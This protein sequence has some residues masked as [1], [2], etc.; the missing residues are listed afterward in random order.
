[1]DSASTQINLTFRWQFLSS[2]FVTLLQLIALVLLGRYLDFKELGAYALFQIIFRFAIFVFEPGM[3]FSLVQRHE[4]GSLLVKRLLERQL[5]Y[6]G[7][8]LILFAVLFILDPNRD[9]NRIILPGFIL[10]LVIGLGAL[11]HNKLILMGK[12]REIAW[13]QALS[14]LGEFLWIIGMVTFVEPLWVF[15]FGL[16]I[17]YF[18]FYGLCFAMSFGKVMDVPSAVLAE[19][20][21]RHIKPARDQMLSQLLSFLQGQYDTLLISG[22]FGMNVLGPYNL[23]TEYSYLAFSKINPL[24]HK[25]YFPALSKA[26]RW[27]SDAIDIMRKNLASYLLVM[28]CIYILLWTNRE[29]LLSM[30]YPDKSDELARMSGFILVVA[31]IKAVNNVLTGYLLAY[32]A[33][34]WILRWNLVLTLVNYLV[35]AVFWWMELPLG[36]FLAFAIG[37]SLFFMLAG[38][39]FLQRVCMKGETLLD[40]DVIL[41][42]LSTVPVFLACVLIVRFSQGPIW[43]LLISVFATFAIVGLLQRQRVSDLLR[44]KIVK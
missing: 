34:R 20:D 43:S 19:M 6:L 5:V 21:T 10:L 4:Y 18:L 32:G 24:F 22:L 26:I 1:M 29:G 36:F 3:F 27:G 7:L 41:V 13:I 33:S 8:C 44:L 23:A 9:L 2:V 14:Y 16:L 31:L 12:Q 42:I 38:A 30:A 39:Y 37:Y 35:C 25:A 40:R 28:V 17:R 15:M 11:P